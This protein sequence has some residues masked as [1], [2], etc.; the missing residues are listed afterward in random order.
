MNGKGLRS[1]VG[2]Q[3]SGKEGRDRWDDWMENKENKEWKHGWS[4]NV[5][6]A[7]LRLDLG[8]KLLI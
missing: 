8:L 2:C 1:E 6:P 4:E 5:L 3:R 7:M